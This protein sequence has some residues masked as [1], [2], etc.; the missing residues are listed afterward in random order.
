MLAAACALHGT[1]LTTPANLPCHGRNNAPVS[2]YTRPVQPLDTDE[3]FD[4]WAPFVGEASRRFGI[5]TTWIRR[6]MQVESGG[7]TT[8][9]GKPI[10]SSAGAMGLMQL[11]PKTYE[12]MRQAYGLGRD[13]FDAHDNIL[14]GTAY[15]REMF[16][17]FG[18]GVFG[19]YNAGP[20]RYEDF[21]EDKE[22]LPSETVSYLAKLNPGG[23]ALI[24]PPDKSL[25][26]PSANA[27]FVTLSTDN[28]GVAREPSH[29]M[30][31]A[32]RRSEANAI[33][34][35]NAQNAAGQSDS[36]QKNLFITQSRSA[37]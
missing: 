8:L 5:P 15:L 28:I 24:V 3:L 17:R 25:S 18:G 33:F 23:A 20:E 31:A 37:P 32:N 35:T 1:V 21:L 19:A 26:M 36:Q 6:V 13:P 27:L 29:T 11:M 9:H 10:T 12:D 4:R 16:E 22:P 2:A 30:Q 7:R 14:A 34:V